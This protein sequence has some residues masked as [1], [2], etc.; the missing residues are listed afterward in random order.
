MLDTNC[1][2]FIQPFIKLGANIFIKLNI[3]ANQV[4]SIALIF[5][6][7]SGI[8][9]YLDFPYIAIALLWF[10]GYLDAVDGTIARHSGSTPFGTV[11]DITFD[12]IVEISLI[13]GLA[14][15]NPNI[16]FLFLCLACSIIISMTIFLVTGSL[17][18]KKSEKSFYY[19]P[20]LAERTE[21]FIMFSLMILFQTYLNYLTLIFIFI[22][23]FTATQ[24]FLEG[25]KILNKLS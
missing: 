25:K 2:K 5:G 21:G 4:T 12:R 17:T 24:R 8:L 23:L 3:T 13:L 6:I 16:N 7:A 22:V 20:G 11:M 19:Q 1:R 10:S 14:L 18:T 9:I 15:K